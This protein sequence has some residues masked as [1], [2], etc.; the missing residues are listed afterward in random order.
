MSSPQNPYGSDPNNPYGGQPDPQNGGA[1]GSDQGYQAPQYGSQPGGYGEQPGYGSQPGGYGDQ[2]G[3]QPEY[4][5]AGGYGD[6][7]GYGQQGYDQQGYGSGFQGYGNDQFSP[8]YDGNDPYNSGYGYGGGDPKARNIWGILALVAGI[9]ALLSSFGA[10]IPIVGIFI[11]IFA[12][13]V[14]IVAVIFGF[15]GLNAAKKGKATNKGLS[16]TGLILGA[17]AIVLSIVLAIA[18]TFWFVDQ[19]EQSSTGAAS[20][21]PA[22]PNSDPAQEPSE[23]VEESTAAAPEETEDAAPPASG[24]GV[25][26]TDGVTMS[27]SVGADKVEEFSAPATGGEIARVEFTIENT[28]GEEFDPGFPLIEC[29]YS[30]GTCEDVFNGAEYDGGLSFAPV[31]AGESETFVMGFM[32]PEADIDSIELSVAI[33]NSDQ[34]IGNPYIFTR[35]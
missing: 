3:S 21:A 34:G 8:A 7:Q 32:V 9:I 6:Q 15:V 18:S 28:S 25:T 1:Y 27:A 30:G 11:G 22:D 26:L 5:A 33:S 13:V 16:I 10:L 17:L 24:E 14:G 12:L 4:Q 2:Y 20:T 31:P 35:G 29:T 23:P 19:V